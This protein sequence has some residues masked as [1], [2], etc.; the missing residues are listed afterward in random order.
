[1]TPQPGKGIPTAQLINERVL[2]LGPGGT[3]T[4]I[5]VGPNLNGILDQSQIPLDVIKLAQRPTGVVEV[6][7]GYQEEWG[8]G[9][10]QQVRRV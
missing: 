3:I 1:L 6:E 5:P 4:S 10:H 8:P 2:S 7:T 9:E